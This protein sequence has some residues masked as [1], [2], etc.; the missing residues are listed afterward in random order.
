MDESGLFYKMMPDKTLKFKGEKCTGGKMS[1]DRIAANMDGSEKRK[2][3]A[4][5]KSRTP[6][7]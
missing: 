5:G 4:I 3:L 6:L 2:L 7:F 1:K